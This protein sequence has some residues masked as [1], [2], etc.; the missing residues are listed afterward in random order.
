MSAD[1][2]NIDDEIDW[3]ELQDFFFED[4]KPRFQEMDALCAAGDA[5]RLSRIGHSLKGS[6]GGVK[7]DRFTDLGKLLEDAGKASDLPQC[8]VACRL[9][10]DEYLKYRPDDASEVSGYFRDTGR[11]AA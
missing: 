1:D 10:R 8:L 9:I 5:H 2:Y 6:G 3:A 4:L 11:A 7:L